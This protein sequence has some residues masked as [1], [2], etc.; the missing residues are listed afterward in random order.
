[1]YYTIYELPGKY[2]FK[3]DPF[4]LYIPDNWYSWYSKKFKKWVD[5]KRIW[6]AQSCLTVC[7]HCRNFKKSTKILN[8]WSRRKW[9]FCSEKLAFHGHKYS[10]LETRSEKPSCVN[11]LM[12]GEVPYTNAAT[13]VFSTIPRTLC[14]GPRNMLR[15]NHAGPRNWLSVLCIVNITIKIQDKEGTTPQKHC[16]CKHN[17]VDLGSMVFQ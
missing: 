14:V 16:N 5:S 3:K 6:C 12:E 2:C 17:Y 4:I 11:I 15:S 10:S 13:M 7:H 1:M 8:V 9:W